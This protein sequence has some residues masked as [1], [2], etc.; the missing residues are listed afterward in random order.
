MHP[1]SIAPDSPTQ[2]RAATESSLRFNFGFA[3][4]FDT[5]KTIISQ[6]SNL[7]EVLGKEIATEFIAKMTGANDIVS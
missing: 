4:W 3:G 1:E 7:S 5:S 6:S 2:S